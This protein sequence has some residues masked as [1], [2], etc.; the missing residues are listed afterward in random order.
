MGSILWGKACY[1]EDIF[2]TKMHKHMRQEYDI[3]TWDCA[4]RIWY[5]MKHK[6]KIIY[7]PRTLL[8]DFSHWG[9]KTWRLCEN[10][11]SSSDL[12]L[13]CKMHEQFLYDLKV[14]SITLTQ[15]LEIMDGC[16]NGGLLIGSFRCVINNKQL[17]CE[18]RLNPRVYFTNSMWNPTVSW[19]WEFD[20]ISFIVSTKD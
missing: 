1:W 6:Q 12:N 19:V 7:H 14:L 11:G 16:L 10:R 8:I 20:S 9:L 4:L 15:D 5:Q 3:N 13:R 18:T 17:I 2:I